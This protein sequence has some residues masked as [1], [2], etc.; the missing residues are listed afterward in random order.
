MLMNKTVTMGK[1]ILP[2][3]S[4]QLSVEIRGVWWLLSREDRTKDGYQRIDP[5]LGADPLGILTYAV[6]HFAAQFMKKDRTENTAD[7]VIHSGKNNTSAVGGYDAY[8][9]MYEVNEQTGMVAH[10]LVGSITPSNTGVTV[11]RNLRVSD[12]KL[13]I[14]LETKTVEGEAITHT[15]LWK[16]IS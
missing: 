12:N 13:F 15:L 10:T 6:T 1:P 11:L 3:P 9:G 4:G 5:V 8:F 14:Q 16:R 7:Q 2:S